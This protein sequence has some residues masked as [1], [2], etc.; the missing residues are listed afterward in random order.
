MGPPG[1]PGLEVSAAGPGSARVEPAVQS[2]ATL[3]GAATE[4]VSGGLGQPEGGQVLKE[5][6]KRQKADPCP[7]PPTVC[8]CFGSMVSFE[9]PVRGAP[10]FFISLGASEAQRVRF[11]LLSH[12]REAGHPA[13]DLALRPLRRSEPPSGKYLARL[14]PPPSPLR[15]HPSAVHK[16]FDLGPLDTQN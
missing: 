12:L 11:S 10:L 4:V 16:Y 5:G 6:N 8:Y 2:R 14:Q 9:S 15:S 13:W 7:C 1:A 3:G